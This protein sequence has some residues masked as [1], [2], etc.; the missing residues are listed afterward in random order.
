M[1]V[2]TAVAIVKAVYIDCLEI[3]LCTTVAAPTVDAVPQ[4]TCK[5]LYTL[6]AQTAVKPTLTSCISSP[7]LYLAIYSSLYIQQKQFPFGRPTHSSTNKY[8]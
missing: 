5:P 7:R 2:Q 6:A 1:L 3:K 4:Q 8:L